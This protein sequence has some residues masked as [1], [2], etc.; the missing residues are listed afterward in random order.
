MTFLTGARH[1]IAMEQVIKPRAKM[2]NRQRMLSLFAIMAVSTITGATSLAAQ[3]TKPVRE[4]K[5]AAQARRHAAA[6]V[7]AAST[8]P[9]PASE[10]MTAQTSP[11][12]GPRGPA[13]QP[14]NK[15]RVSWDSRGLEI[16]ASNSSLNQ[17]LRQVAAYTGAKL[18]GLT[19]DQRVFGTY[20]PGPGSDVLLKLLDGSGYNV[21]MVGGR[22]G[23]APLEIILSIRSPF[24][25]QPAVNNRNRSN[26]EDDEAERLKPEPQPDPPP[27]ADQNP[28]NIG[29]PPR[30]PGEVMDEILHRQQKIDEQAQ[31]EQRNNPQQ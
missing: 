12:P 4:Q 18:Q 23:E 3:A 1:Q 15:A 31:Q 28:F 20:G 16:E 9:Q 21:L 14:P 29:G 2:V 26:A 30:D 25:P 24:S 27:P 8:Q 10:A 22:D 13:G 19:E 17:I 5:A 7:N 6:Q 11:A